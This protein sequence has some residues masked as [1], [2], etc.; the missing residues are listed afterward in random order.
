MIKLIQRHPSLTA[1]V[2]A[3]P[4]CEREAPTVGR[5]MAMLVVAGRLNSRIRRMPLKDLARVEAN[6]RLIVDNKNAD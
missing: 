3:A 1:D 4:R 5:R 6:D 2:N